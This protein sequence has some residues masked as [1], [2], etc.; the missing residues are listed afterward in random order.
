MD[1]LVNDSNYQEIKAKHR[2]AKRKYSQIHFQKGEL[3]TVIFSSEA[4]WRLCEI[5]VAFLM[6]F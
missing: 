5:E 2:V 6:S 3:E 1:R 4:N